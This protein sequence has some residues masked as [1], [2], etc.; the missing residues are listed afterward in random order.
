M[1]EYDKTKI[2][3]GIGSLRRWFYIGI[4]LFLAMKKEE[5]G[6]YSS[7]EHTEIKKLK[8]HSTAWG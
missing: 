6:F 3:K 7:Q 8:L 1:K 4:L 2:Q 5:S